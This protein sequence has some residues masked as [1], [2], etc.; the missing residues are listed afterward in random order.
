MPIFRYSSILLFIKTSAIA[1]INIITIFR[2]ALYVRHLTH[3][4]SK[5]FVVSKI[6]LAAFNSGK[7]KQ[8][9]SLH[10]KSGQCFLL[11]FVGFVNGFESF[12][13][14]HLAWVPYVAGLAPPLPANRATPWINLNNGLR[15]WIGFIEII[16]KM[17]KGLFVKVLFDPYLPMLFLFSLYQNIMKDRLM[18]QGVIIRIFCWLSLLLILIFTC[19]V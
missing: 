17:S 4:R 5:K 15:A 9:R 3:S 16:F 12:R 6:K 13:A 18:Q 1:H 8:V 7:Y 2:T 10:T 14:A 11:G 19:L